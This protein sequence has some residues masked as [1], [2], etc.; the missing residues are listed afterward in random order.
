M[1]PRS[2]GRN[3]GD[4]VG[5][6]LGA[7]F[8]GMGEAG[9]MRSSRKA[10]LRRGL[11]FLADAPAAAVPPAV[12]S[13]GPVESPYPPRV[14]GDLFGTVFDLWSDPGDLRLTKVSVGH[15]GRME[16]MERIG[17]D[18]HR[19]AKTIVPELALKHR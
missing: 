9:T 10:G 7:L 15:R 19:A 17:H 18:L 2:P 1:K 13:A 4:S 16:D 12:L 8:R 3:G 14:E 6:R 11:E 5:A